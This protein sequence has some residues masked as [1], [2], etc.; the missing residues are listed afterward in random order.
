MLIIIGYFALRKQFTVIEDK[1]QVKA[2]ILSSTIA[3]ILTLLL[4]IIAF[5]LNSYCWQWFENRIYSLTEQEAIAYGIY[6]F[7]LLYEQLAG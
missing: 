5:F 2:L 1:V 6:Y 4:A 3:F 7:F